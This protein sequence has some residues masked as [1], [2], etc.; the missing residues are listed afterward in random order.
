MNNGSSDRSGW[1]A[2]PLRTA[3]RSTR[4]APRRGALTFALAGLATAALVSACAAPSTTSTGASGTASATAAAAI[5]AS[6]VDQQLRAMLPASIKSSGVLRIATTTGN[7]PM[8][9]ATV[10]GTPE[11]LDIDLATAAAQ[12]LGL[13]PQFFETQFSGLIA[14]ESSGRT[15][16]IWGAMNDNALRE[17]QVTFVDYFK[18]GF[19]VLVPK[20]NPKKIQSP[21][22]FCGLTFAES[23]GSVFQT[24]VPQ[25]SQQNCTS[26]GKSPINVTI[27]PDNQSTFQALATN[28]V[29][30]IMAAQ[31]Q[32]AYQ[33]DLNSALDAVPSINLNVVHYGIGVTPSNTQLIACMKATVEK[34]IEN[35]T[36]MD[37]LNKWKL[38][39]QA[40]PTAVINQ[41]SA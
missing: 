41:P 4:S 37:I 19:S 1:F 18:H 25:L 30:A 38:Q 22:D 28:R 12:L 23:Q 17:K 5:P 26:K 10:G 35:G 34:M 16:V 36:Y 13:K 2:K 24:L 15:D 33:A 40:I 7:A 8:D 20:G 3:Y 6:G 39:A 27:Y 29:N 11:G 9:F 32:V 21:A 31:E 14:A